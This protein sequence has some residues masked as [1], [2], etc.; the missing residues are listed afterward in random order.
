MV[1]RGTAISKQSVGVFFLWI[2]QSWL[3]VTQKICAFI[4]ITL[5][6]STLL[7][8]ISEKKTRGDKAM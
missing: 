2:S 6:F 3:L 5:L 4:H 7:T 1:I 8:V